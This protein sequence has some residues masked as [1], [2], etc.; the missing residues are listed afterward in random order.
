MRIR[1]IKPEFW[2][3][4]DIAALDWATRL[5]F[6]GIWSYVDD[7]GVGRDNPKLILADLFPLEDNPRDILATVSRGLQRLRDVGLISRYEVDGKP[8]LH[9]S[10]WAD[11][12][13]ID[14]PN[15]P[16]Y[17]LPTSENVVIRDTLA[18]V[19]RVSR[20][21]PLPGAG[22]QRNRGTGEQGITT[23]AIADA[24]PGKPVADPEGFA[25]FWNAYDKRAGRK[26]AVSAF[27]SAVK[28][29]GVTPELLTAAATEYVGWQKREGKHPKYTKNASTWLNGEHWTDERSARAA[30]PTSRIDEHLS[31]VER[32]RAQEE[33]PAWA[34]QIGDGS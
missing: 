31:L 10:S 27:R 4:E 1:S 20:E 3:S 34:P 30:L 17:P 13:R 22:E 21:T 33:A 29:R 23:S 14:R 26:A 5:L 11:H 19:S 8:F 28:K 12:Q 7:N 16:R 9:V 25:A 15:K 24:A 32:L 18:S 2:T 6:I